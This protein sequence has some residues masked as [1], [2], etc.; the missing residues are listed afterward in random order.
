MPNMPLPFGAD[1]SAVDLGADKLAVINMDMLVK[2]TDVPRT[3]SLWQA[4]RKAVIINII[5]LAAKGTQA[6]ALLA[7]LGVPPKLTK[8]DIQQI[9]RGLNSG[10]RE[11]GAYIREETLTKPLN[12]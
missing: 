8:T 5:D 9:G 10:A 1:T 3:M 6:I 2:K 7:S 4:A 12:W 11:Y